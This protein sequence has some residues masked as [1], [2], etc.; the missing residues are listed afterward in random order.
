MGARDI[1]VIGASGGGVEAAS[2]LVKTLPG[3]LKAAI[4]LAIHMAPTI[5]SELP[6][7]LS[8]N[9]SLPA[10]QAVDGE[11]IQA[12]HIYVAP[13]GRHLLLGPEKVAVSVDPAES[14]YRPAVD[15]L[16]RS[17]AN[18]YGPRVIGVVLTGSLDD[19]TAGLR[20]VKERGG[21]TIV[22]DPDEAHWSSMPASAIAAVTPHEVLKLDQIGPAIAKVVAQGLPEMARAR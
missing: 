18:F 11:P 3:D 20:T 22:Q 16:F 8:R 9:G 2:R 21:Y 1:V 19:G 4:F 5:P 12:G 15:V 6:R 7:I 17:A 14:L 13:P 10:T